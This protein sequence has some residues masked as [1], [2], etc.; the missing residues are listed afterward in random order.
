MERNELERNTSESYWRKSRHSWA[1][2]SA[3]N[4]FSLW[5]TAHAEIIEPILNCYQAITLFLVLLQAIFMAFLHQWAISWNCAKH[6][7]GFSCLLNWYT[8]WVIGDV[9]KSEKSDSEIMKLIFSNNNSNAPCTSI[10]FILYSDIDH[11]PPFFG[12]FRLC[13]WGLCNVVWIS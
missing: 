4:I 10:S 12:S 1:L 3:A 5:I 9:R 13:E 6:F 8:C 2:R 11:P 7:M